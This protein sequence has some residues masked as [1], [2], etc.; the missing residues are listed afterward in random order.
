[1]MIHLGKQ[2]QLAV[3]QLLTE[4]HPDA[5]ITHEALVQ[6]SHILGPYRERD[7]RSFL[8]GHLLVASRAGRE[9]A[10]L[11]AISPLD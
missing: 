6:V 7:G 5:S 4:K 9:F 1:M 11:T 2:A 3:D 8:T 10:F